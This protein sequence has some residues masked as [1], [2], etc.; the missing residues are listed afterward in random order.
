M[1]CQAAP[2]I[3]KGRR[4]FRLS[5]GT[6]EITSLL[7]GGH[8]ADFRMCDSPHNLLFE[9]PW[10]TIEPQ[11]FSPAIHGK[12]YGDGPVGRLLSGYTG[13]ALV[14]GYFGMPTDEEAARGLPLHGEAVAAEWKIVDSWAD[15]RGASATLEVMLPVYRLLFRRKLFLNVGASVIQI[16]ESV[17][18]R[19]GT[20]LDFQWVEHVA[21]GEPLFAASESH[22]YVSA[23]RGRTWPH[24]YEGLELLQ[25]GADFEWPFAPGIEGKQIDLSEPFTEDGTGFVASLLCEPSRAT[26]FIALHNRKLGLAAGYVFDSSQFPWIAL[27][28][29]NRARTY[30]PWDGITR[31]RGV[32]FGTSPM[33]A[34]LKEAREMKTL[35]DVPVYRTLAAGTRLSTT[36]HLFATELSPNWPSITD[37][38]SS[39]DEL[40]LIWGP[41]SSRKL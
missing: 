36:Y 13:H 24:G 9:S 26:G 14:L 7:G 16:E 41:N 25:A 37:I 30:S 19:G 10:E 11:S 2:I 23:T 38:A 27:W 12:R 22:L 34:G 28:E 20:N 8:I 15:D 35:F 6:V 17:V 18:N 3:W 1:C 32:E 33:P 39:D 29:E 31:A 5:N 40:S 4:A 21:F